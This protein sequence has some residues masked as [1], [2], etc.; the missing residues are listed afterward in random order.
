M[1][2]TKKPKLSLRQSKILKGRLEGKTQQEIGIEVYPDAQPGT[3]RVK[4]AQEL[5]KDTM[6][7][8]LLHA[9]EKL[10]ITPE[11]ALKP[12]DDA[13]DDDDVRTR[14]MGSDR[15]L[16]AMGMIT[17]KDEPNTNIFIGNSFKVDSYVKD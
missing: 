6:Q 13:L 17:K 5:Q 1:E 16:K 8:A 3:A 4:V 15:A 7:Q 11:R 10:N 9:M 14:L 2:Q 12:I